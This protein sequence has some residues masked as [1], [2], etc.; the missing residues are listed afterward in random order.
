MDEPLDD[1]RDNMGAPA[2]GEGFVDSGEYG[3]SPDIVDDS[4]I[5]RRNN[6]KKPGRRH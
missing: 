4:R 1:G 2:S 6:I 3:L 5:V